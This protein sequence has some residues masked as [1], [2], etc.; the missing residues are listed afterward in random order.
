M[1][2]DMLKIQDGGAIVEKVNYANKFLS[3]KSFRVLSDLAKLKYT[4][5]YRNTLRNYSCV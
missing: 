1:H 4:Y 3:I 5:K 2:C